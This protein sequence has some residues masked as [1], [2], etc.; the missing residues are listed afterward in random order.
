MIEVEHAGTV[1]T[2]QL[3]IAAISDGALGRRR[4][5]GARFVGMGARQLAGAVHF[6]AAPRSC[7]LAVTPVT[8]SYFCNLSSCRPPSQR[9]IGRIGS[10]PGAMVALAEWRQLRQSAS[11]RHT[12]RGL[13]CF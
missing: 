5:G 3:S 11:G 10:L 13:Q 9:W 8:S 2:V 12:E 6:F 4:R 1:E 7:Q